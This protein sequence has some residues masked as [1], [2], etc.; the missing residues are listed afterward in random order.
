MNRWKSTPS[1]SERRHSGTSNGFTLV[2]ILVAISI[3][4]ILMSSIYGIFTSISTT[5]D[6][7]DTD[8]EAYHRAR[9]IFDR[10]GREIRGAY[11]T[12]KNDATLF[13]GGE[14]SDGTIFLELSTTAVSP[15]S[16]EG[17]GFALVRYTLEEDR[18]ADDGSKVMLRSERALLTQTEAREEPTAM[19]LAPGISAFSVRFYA[20]AAWHESW[21]AAANGL[22]VMVEV[23]LRTSDRNGEEIPFLTAFELPVLEPMQ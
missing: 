7:L 10:L 11:Y 21:D 12:P 9:V 18:E 15:L 23:S 14:T 16:S 19:R 6:R 17:T 8:S 4:A 1:S 2:E 20:D 3:I 13:R 22:P 5:K